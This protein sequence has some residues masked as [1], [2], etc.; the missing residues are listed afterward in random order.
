MN[1][2]VMTP[3]SHRLGVSEPYTSLSLMSSD[4]A[5]FEIYDGGTTPIGPRQLSHCTDI[6]DMLVYVRLHE[7]PR[8]PVPNLAGFKIHSHSLK[9]GSYRSK[10]T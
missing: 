8:L 2:Q 9:Q 6:L 3:E 4:S 1:L 7:Y 5:G 10:R